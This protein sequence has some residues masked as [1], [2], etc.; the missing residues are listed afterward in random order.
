MPVE[1]LSQEQ[2]DEG[3]KLLGQAQKE[4]AVSRLNPFKSKGKKLEA[5]AGIVQAYY[6]AIPTKLPAKIDPRRGD[7]AVLR[8]VR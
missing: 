1:A 2:I 4:Q 8:A 7:R 6:N 5:L 3:R